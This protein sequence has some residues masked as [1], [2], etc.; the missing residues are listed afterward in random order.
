MV[1]S[2]KSLTRIKETSVHWSVMSSVAV[3]NVF[4]SKQY[5]CQQ[6]VLF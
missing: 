5:T 1:N 6:S 4:Y 2:F 3:D